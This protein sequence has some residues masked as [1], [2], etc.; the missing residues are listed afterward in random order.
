MLDWLPVNK[1]FLYWTTIGSVI[2]AVASVFIVPWII[3]KLPA[4]YFNSDEKRRGPLARLFDS[5]NSNRAG[6][7][8]YKIIKN[9]VAGLII[10]AGL[11]MLLLPGQGLL[12]L[13]FGLLLA[14]VPGKQRLINWLVCRKKVLGFLN[15]IR[16][17]G[18]KPPF[19]IT[20]CDDRT[21]APARKA[22]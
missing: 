4:D 13:V 10:L 22:A 11:A 16:R 7:I 1:T 14:D 19:T 8:T 15:W 12:V 5:N 9:V 21:P 17:K 18:K 3:I 6:R 20:A 2:L